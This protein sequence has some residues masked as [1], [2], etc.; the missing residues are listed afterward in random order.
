KL[1]R[2]LS[3]GVH[4]ELEMTRQLGELGFANIA[5]LLGEVSRIGVDGEPTLL[6]I[7]QGY[8][9]NQGD[10]WEWTQNGL[11]RAIRDALVSGSAPD[12]SSHAALAELEEFSA[13]LG[14]RLG[15]MHALLAQPSDKPEFAPQL[16][17]AE[18][19]RQ[20]NLRVQAQ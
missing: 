7:A 9:S 13:V 11:E 4:P 6:M 1:L 5:P 20:L 15:E 14:R 8:L 2:R 18:Q 17:D 12:D 16:I 10:A 19:A 3:P